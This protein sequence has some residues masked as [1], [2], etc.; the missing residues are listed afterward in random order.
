MHPQKKKISGPDQENVEARRSDFH[1]LKK[2]PENGCSTNH[3]LVVESG[4]GA[5]SSWRHVPS[6]TLTLN[7]WRGFSV[8]LT[9]TQGLRDRSSF[10]SPIWP[11]TY[12]VCTRISNLTLPILF[13][14]YIKIFKCDTRRNIKNVWVENLQRVNFLVLSLCLSTFRVVVTFNCSNTFTLNVTQTFL[15]VPK[16]FSKTG[17]TK[18]NTLP[19]SRAITHGIDYS[20]R[21]KNVT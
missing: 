17:I 11:Q 20:G 5:P 7:R 2:C 19:S 12:L 6:R 10:G 9:V 8:A 3:A 1:G 16:H 4:R 18:W 14:A 15:Q 13:G 21:V